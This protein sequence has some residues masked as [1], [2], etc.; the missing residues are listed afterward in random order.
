MHSYWT[1]SH[2]ELLEMDRKAK[3]FF[4]DVA[5]LFNMVH[6][7]KINLGCSRLHSQA[8]SR[9]ILQMTI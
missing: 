6:S 4:N 2:F 1:L 9:V 7:F 3:R 5:L 8:V